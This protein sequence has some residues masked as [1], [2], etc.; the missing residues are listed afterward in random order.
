MV[1]NYRSNVWS[2]RDLLNVTAGNVGPIPGGGLPEALYELTGTR[3]ANSITAGS[4]HVNGLS[5]D[6]DIRMIGLGQAHEVQITIPENFPILEQNSLLAYEI[7]LRGNFWAGGENDCPPLDLVVTAI[8]ANGG[9]IIQDT[10]PLPNFIGR[11]PANPDITVYNSEDYRTRVL[12]Q[13]IRGILDYEDPNSPNPDEPV[14]LVVIPDDEVVPD[15]FGS[16]AKSTTDAE[17]LFLRFVDDS[18][19][20]FII[21][22]NQD[23]NA[24]LP[25][26]DNFST[27]LDILTNRIINDEND[28]TSADRPMQAGPNDDF[29]RP[30]EIPD[31]DIDVLGTEVAYTEPLNLPADTSAAV[32]NFNFET[33]I[34]LMTEPSPPTNEIEN[35]AVFLFPD[36]TV[37]SVS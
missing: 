30:T 11:D 34:D 5:A 37:I 31:N 16:I 21:Q 33:L 35:R 19:I 15:D 6:T 24:R 1:W 8:R 25:S 29:G 13:V 27:T 4:P 23:G 17:V 28:L 26:D 9:E 3:T 12:Y 18:N 10:I 36:M 22:F 20:S 2:K 14:K 7:T 32:F